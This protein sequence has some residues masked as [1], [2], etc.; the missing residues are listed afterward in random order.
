MKILLH[1][2][3]IIFFL[4]F[5]AVLLQH[6]PNLN[7][8]YSVQPLEHTLNLRPSI[9]LKIWKTFNNYILNYCLSVIHSILTTLPQTPTK[10]LLKPLDI[11]SMS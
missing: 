8:F 7:L 4:D 9:F 3:L 5:I 2:L 6:N 1:L 10:C 11:V